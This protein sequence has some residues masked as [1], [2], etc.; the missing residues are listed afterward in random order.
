MI[1]NE[2]EMAELFDVQMAKVNCFKLEYIVDWVWHATI[3]QSFHDV[4]IS[5]F[6]MIYLSHNL[7]NRRLSI[8]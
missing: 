3:P 1:W 8:K 2:R 5:S 4:L 7:F 6:L